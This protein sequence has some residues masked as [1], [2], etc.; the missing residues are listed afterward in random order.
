MKLIILD[1]DGTIGDT[2]PIIIKTFLATLREAGLEE[3]TAGEIAA[4][5]G[6]PLVKAFAQLH[7]LSEEQAQA[8]ADVY[9]RI[10]MENNKPGAVPVFPHVVETIK[11]L[12]AQGCI[13]T[14]ASSRGHESLQAFL[15]EMRLNPYI[16]LLLGVE[17]VKQAKPHPEAVLKTMEQF[18]VSAE[19]TLVVGDT[20]YDILMGNNAHAHTC[21]VTYGNG[22]H[23]ELQEAGAEYIIDDFADILKLTTN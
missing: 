10:F 3:K 8:C 20:K 17:D 21:G 15:D 6:L 4:T 23:Q 13:V 14:I 5:I 18:G 22:S 7:A 2:K 11:Q 1:F 9:R 16:S 19:E 12:K